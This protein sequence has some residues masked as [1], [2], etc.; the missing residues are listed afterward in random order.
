MRP[1]TGKK[2]SLLAKFE[3]ARSVSAPVHRRFSISPICSNCVLPP[4]PE[5]ICSDYN[6]YRPTRHQMSGSD[7]TRHVTGS[8]LRRVK[9]PQLPRVRV[10]HRQ[11]PF[12]AMFSV[13]HLFYRTRPRF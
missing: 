10:P 1:I 11:C 8:S 3:F 13:P 12:P 2:Y 5:F 7:R 4:G 9:L 6:E